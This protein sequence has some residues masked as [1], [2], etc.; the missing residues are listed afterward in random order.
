MCPRSSAEKQGPARARAGRAGYGESDEATR[1]AD[2]D[3]SGRGA[4]D[5]SP[6]NEGQITGIASKGT[7]V[8]AQSTTGNRAEMRT[9]RRTVEAAKNESAAAEPKGDEPAAAVEGMEMGLKAAVMSLAGTIDRCSVGIALYVACFS[10]TER[11][12]RPGPPAE[13]ARTVFRPKSVT[14]HAPGT[15]G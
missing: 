1:Y 8:L 10:A 7:K 9:T 6:S 5:G 4:E 12:A 2:S 14:V 3:L 13:G 15:P 11:S